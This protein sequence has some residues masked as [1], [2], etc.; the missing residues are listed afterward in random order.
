MRLKS[1]HTYSN[2]KS[3]S[4]EKL[5]LISEIY[6]LHGLCS[7]ADVYVRLQKLGYK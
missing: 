7:I 4:I 2:P 5:S 1:R 3:H 6:S